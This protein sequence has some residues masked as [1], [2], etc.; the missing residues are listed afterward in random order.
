M[1]PEELRSLYGPPSQR[2]VEKILPNL[3]SHC[4][5]FIKN[6]SFLILGTTN[7]KSI[8]LSPKGDPKGFVKVID[9]NIL[10]LPDRP[11]NNRIDGLLNISINPKVALLFFITNVTETLRIQGTAEIISEKIVLDNHKIKNRLPKTVT[12]ITIDTVGFHCGKA[13]IRSELWQHEKWP[14]DRPIESLYNIIEDQTGLKSLATDEKEVNK[15]Y[16]KSL[17]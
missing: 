15:I 11:G 9:K 14:K 8:D 16:E 2:A 3:D 6:S 1:S 17:Y 4:I 12:R 10:E 7:E 5:Q 13:L